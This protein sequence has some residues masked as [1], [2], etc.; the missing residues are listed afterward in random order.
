[1]LVVTTGCQ[2]AKRGSCGQDQYLD[3]YC[4]LGPNASHLLWSHQVFDKWPLPASKPSSQ[5]TR[6]YLLNLSA[7][8]HRAFKLFDVDVTPLIAPHGGLL[9]T[10]FYDRNGLILRK[11]EV[12]VKNPPT[13]LRIFRDEN[14]RLLIDDAQRLHPGKI[15]FRFSNPVVAV[16]LDNQLSEWPMTVITMMSSRCLMTCLWGQMVPIAWSGHSYR[17]PRPATRV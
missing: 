17:Q 4:E 5:D 10:T 12:P 16:N 2:H 8:A 9:A 3:G 6:A 15:S 13:S 11:F 14:G 7:R 1:M